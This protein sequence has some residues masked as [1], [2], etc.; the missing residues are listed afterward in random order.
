MT[1]EVHVPWN[2]RGTVNDYFI[3]ELKND[4]LTQW[5][6]DT[7]TYKL[8]AECLDHAHDVAKLLA[9]RNIKAYIVNTNH[10]P[11]ERH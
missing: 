7:H 9:R 2:H 3:E 8:E 1:I 6:T 5:T 4:P 10:S 11:F